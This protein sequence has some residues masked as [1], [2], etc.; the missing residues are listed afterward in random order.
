MQDASGKVKPCQ[1]VKIDL[2]TFE[3]LEK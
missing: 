3:L 1:R 2:Q